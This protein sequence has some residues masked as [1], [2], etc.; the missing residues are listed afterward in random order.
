MFPC[1]GLLLKIL[2]VLR[3][4]KI[5]PQDGGDALEIDDHPI[6]MISPPILCPGYLTFVKADM[7]SKPLY[8]SLFIVLFILLSHES[9]LVVVVLHTVSYDLGSKTG[10]GEEN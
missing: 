5:K 8:G 4:T 7:G 1:R 3:E 9:L 10:G 2:C 6:K